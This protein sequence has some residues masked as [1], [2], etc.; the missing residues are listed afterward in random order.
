M[1]LLSIKE[2][3]EENAE[4]MRHEHLRENLELSV[5]YF[6]N[7]GYHPPWIG[8]YAQMNDEWVGAAA[9]KGKPVGGKVE[10]AYTTFSPFQNKGIGT[11]LC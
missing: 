7:I 2:R 5:K 6:A 1:K 11:E 8:Y 10:I 4:L 3:L 9:F